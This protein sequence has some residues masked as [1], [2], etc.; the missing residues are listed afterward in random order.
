LV[1]EYK[2]IVKD[3]EKKASGEGGL[4]EDRIEKARQAIEDN[5]TRDEVMRQN[6]Y[7]LIDKKLIPGKL[8]DK[9]KRD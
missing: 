6:L 4:N 1:E 8:T 7:F 3:E 5:E 9:L 2:L